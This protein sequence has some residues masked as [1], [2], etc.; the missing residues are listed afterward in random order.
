[1]ALPATRELE[2]DAL[3]IASGFS[4]SAGLPLRH[5]ACQAISSTPRLMMAPTTVAQIEKAVSNAEP[6]ATAINSVRQNLASSQI[7]TAADMNATAARTHATP[8]ID[9][10]NG[11][12]MVHRPVKYSTDAPCAAFQNELTP[13]K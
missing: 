3:V 9:S 8:S 10:K 2:P 5:S 12:E 1:M 6:N 7:A 4:S 11:S 13:A